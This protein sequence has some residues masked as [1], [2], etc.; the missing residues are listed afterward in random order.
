LCDFLCNCFF[1]LFLSIL[2]ILYSLHFSRCFLFTYQIVEKLAMR[3]MDAVAVIVCSGL[4]IW[5]VTT[6]RTP[7]N[8]LGRERCEEKK[9]LLLNCY[10]YS[11]EKTQWNLLRELK[12]ERDRDRERCCTLETGIVVQLHII[13]GTHV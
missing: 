4:E 3:E 6:V 1:R 5:S 2:Y 7:K 10:S 11:E 9:L 12:R 8:P 13:Q